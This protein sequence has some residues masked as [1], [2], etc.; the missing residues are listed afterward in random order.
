MKKHIYLV[1]K[2]I[3]AGLILFTVPVKFSGQPESIELFTQL[4]SN[5]ITSLL[6][7]GGEPTGRYVVAT[8]ELVAGILVLVPKTSLFGGLMIMGLMAGAFVTHAL[9]LGFGG[10]FPIAVTAFVFGALTAYLAKQRKKQK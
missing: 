9:V 5:P 4:G 2:L 3:T 7:F 10:M 1:V 6:A 8:L